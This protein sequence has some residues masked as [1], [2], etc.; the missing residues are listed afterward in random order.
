MSGFE[1]DIQIRSFQVDINQNL[2]IPSLLSINQERAIHHTERLGYGKDKTLDK[3]YLWVIAAQHFEI[4]TLP[5]YGQDVT[6][7]TYPGK[8]RNY[9]LPRYLEIKDRKGNTLVR[10][11]TIWTR[12]NK[13]SRKI[14]N[15]E[16]IGI[17]I[18]GEEVKNRP[19]PF[20]RH[21]FHLTLPDRKFIRK[22]DY[23][24]CDLNGHINNT[25][26]VEECRKRIP[27]EYLKK[28]PVKVIEA[29]YNQEVRYGFGFIVHHA[30]EKSGYLF[31]S[32]P[33][34]LFFGF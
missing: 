32:V 23:R 12:I 25:K 34:T 10:G 9:F 2:T 3:G 21:P 18:E 22:A 1:T 15:P 30:K 5:V 29:K 33:F 19:S 6:L 16:K 28:H 24:N 7:I 17:L 4:D 11:S 20:G 14:L 13:R 26:Y 31:S 8:Q 27:K